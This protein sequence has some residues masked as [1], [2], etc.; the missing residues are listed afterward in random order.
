MTRWRKRISSSRSRIG[1]SDQ[2]VD[3]S[4]EAREAHEITALR[5]ADGNSQQGRGQELVTGAVKWM[6]LRI[7]RG[8]TVVNRARRLGVRS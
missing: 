3:L 7:C 1:I 8:D 5:R 4:I 2:L 6:W